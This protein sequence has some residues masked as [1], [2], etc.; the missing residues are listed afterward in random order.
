MWIGTCLVHNKHRE[1]AKSC[2][3]KTCG[4]GAS[5]FAPLG[6]FWRDLSS[7]LW[8]LPL[9]LVSPSTPTNPAHQLV[10]LQAQPSWQLVAPG[11]A[12]N[13][14]PLVKQ[15]VFENNDCSHI[16]D[17][18]GQPSPKVTKDQPLSERMCEDTK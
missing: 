14:A 1:T 4:A 12:Q 17:N 9:R 18:Q 5:S 7:P 10:F 11:G 3:R 2:A 15:T 6:V 16:L 13:T 8:P